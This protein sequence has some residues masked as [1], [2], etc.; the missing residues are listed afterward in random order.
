MAGIF[1]VYQGQVVCSFMHRR[2]SGRPDYV[3]FVQ[4]A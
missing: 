4:T 3:K 2:A 1:A